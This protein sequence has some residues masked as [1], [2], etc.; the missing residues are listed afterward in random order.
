MMNL[1]GKRLVIPYYKAY[2]GLAGRNLSKIRIFNYRAVEV[3]K[4]LF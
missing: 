1:F 4:K 2:I 3:A